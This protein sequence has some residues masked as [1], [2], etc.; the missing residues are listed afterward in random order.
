[1][2][3][4]DGALM[5]ATGSAALGVIIRDHSEAELPFLSECRLLFNCW[6]AKKLRREHAWKE[7]G[8][9]SMAKPDSI[10]KAFMREANDAMMIPF[11]RFPL[12][13][14]VVF[15]FLQLPSTPPLHVREPALPPPSRHPTTKHGH[16]AFPCRLH[17]FSKLQLLSVAS[18]L[19]C[20]RDL[21]QLH[22]WSHLLCLRMQGR[23][24]R[25]ASKEKRRTG[26]GEKEFD[27]EPIRKVI[28]NAFIFRMALVS[29]ESDKWYLMIEA[30]MG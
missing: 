7:S 12:L 16:L 6:D 20:A 13:K 9:W 8:Y 23:N 11:M 1:M 2:I 28:D 5:E 29:L 27:L 26:K 19:P 24:K 21:V 14:R 15:L 22:R 25:E 10:L 30:C 17:D 3:N 18:Q 4:V